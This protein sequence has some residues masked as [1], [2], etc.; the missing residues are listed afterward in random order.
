MMCKAWLL[1]A[2]AAAAAVG[3]AQGRASQGERPSEL[4]AQYSV[5]EVVLSALPHTYVAVG[6]IREWDWCNVA[7]RSFCTRAL[8]Q[9]KKVDWAEKDGGK[10]EL[11]S[12]RARSARP[13]EAARGRA[14]G[15]AAAVVS[16][17]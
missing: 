13:R 9:R 8:N 3:V 4:V 6:G 2:A 15:S 16:D 5:P 10:R 17:A 14:N 1:L 12:R 7:G 11:W